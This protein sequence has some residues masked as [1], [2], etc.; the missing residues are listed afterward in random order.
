M[1]GEFPVQDI[2]EPVRT[3]KRMKYIVQKY[4][5]RPD[6][7]TVERLQHI[8]QHFIA[9]Y[10]SRLNIRRAWKQQNVRQ[11]SVHPSDMTDQV[12]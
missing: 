10:K 5:S 1:I 11:R 12:L 3:S 2:E 9:I 7:D 6:E 4:G 8:L